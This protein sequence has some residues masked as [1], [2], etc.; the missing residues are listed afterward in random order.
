M[1][2]GRLNPN[3]PP[4]FQ[5]KTFTRLFMPFT[6]VADNP[7]NGIFPFKRFRVD[8]LM[9]ISLQNSLLKPC[10]REAGLT[11][12]SSG[13]QGK[14]ILKSIPALHFYANTFSQIFKTKICP[15]L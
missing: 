13:A 5:G 9:M 11:L 15:V 4:L 2:S 14:P 10:S 6:L 8:A 12:S 3:P 7:F 1:S